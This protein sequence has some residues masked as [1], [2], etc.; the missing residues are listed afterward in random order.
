M[1]RRSGR[2]RAVGVAVIALI[3]GASLALAGTK[4]DGK[5]VELP[6]AAS[7]AVDFARDVRPI[8]EKACYDCHGAKKQKSDYR[9]DVAESA[10]RGGSIGGAVVPGDGAKSPM[11][12]YVAGTHDEIRMP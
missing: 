9:L 5:K 11:I 10:L 3:I 6:P 2:G 8:F 4:G 7:R 12:Q 1:I